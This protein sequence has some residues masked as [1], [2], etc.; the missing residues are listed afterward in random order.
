MT[1][2]ELAS[3][4]MSVLA[5]AISAGSAVI[6]GLARRRAEAAETAAAT[7]ETAAAE[8][9]V[10]ARGLAV[11]VDDEVIEALRAG[12]QPSVTADLRVQQLAAWR[13]EHRRVLPPPR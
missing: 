7:T 6:T 13:D 9:L 2:L 5:I 3:I 11:H 4:V 8:L 10:I 1:D 12:Q